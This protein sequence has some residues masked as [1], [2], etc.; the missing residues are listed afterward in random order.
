MVY[1]LFMEC[2]PL[3]VFP[4]SGV[5]IKIGL[6]AGRKSLTGGN[7]RRGE[8]QG[9]ETFFNPLFK[10]QYL[11]TH[12]YTLTHRIQLYVPLVSILSAAVAM[13]LRFEWM[14]A[15]LE[16]HCC[17]L[18]EPSPWLSWTKGTE[19]GKQLSFSLLLFAAEM[20][21]GTICFVKFTAPLARPMCTDGT[22]GLYWRAPPLRFCYIC[23]TQ[24]ERLLYSIT[25]LFDAENTAMDR[26]EM[27]GR[28]QRMSEE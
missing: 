7:I 9:N 24:L 3:Y 20:F 17:F 13:S 12:T 8:E 21:G 10:K 2:L 27:V 6:K 15:T 1:A 11:Y 23:S 4:L 18:S 28:G 16:S 25:L 26:M 19:N 14:K 5:L 22:L